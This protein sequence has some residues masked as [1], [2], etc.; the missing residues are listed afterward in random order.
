MIAEREGPRD[1]PPRWRHDR[2]EQ[3]PIVGVTQADVG[4]R[5]RGGGTKAKEVQGSRQPRTK[6][7]GT[8]T[9]ANRSDVDTW[10]RTGGDDKRE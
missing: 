1:Q 3:Y 5:D 6:A 2:P 9:T 4:G 8:H 10:K 7:T